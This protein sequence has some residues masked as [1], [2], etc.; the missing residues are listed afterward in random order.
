MTPL[1]PLARLGEHQKNA[2][3]RCRASGGFEE[4]VCKYHCLHGRH[5][6]RN[7]YY[8]AGD[9]TSPDVVRSN[10]TRIRPSAIINTAAPVASDDKSQSDVN[11]K[12]TKN[13]LEVAVSIGHVEAFIY[14]SSSSIMKGS[15]HD[16]VTE[17]APILTSTSWGGDR[18]SRSKAM[19]DAAVLESNEKGELRTVSLRQAVVYAERDNQFIP[20]ALQVLREGRQR[21]QIGNNT[22]LLDA[23]S[24]Y[25]AAQAHIL[26]VK[27]LLQCRDEESPK[28]DG[29]AFFS[30]TAIH[31]RS[32]RL[33]AR[34]GLLQVIGRL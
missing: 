12:G 26:A 5:H 30:L 25:N 23:I 9:V 17:D 16:F 7:A 24:A 4:P 31:F 6:Y 20:G 19:A 15:S 2:E 34:Y 3:R 22:N 21:Y 33:S 18:Y 13:L 32:G 27:A 8:H 29:E 14:T 28:V 11:I 1:A 10:I